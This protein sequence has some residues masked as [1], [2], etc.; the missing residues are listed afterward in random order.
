MLKPQNDK[1]EKI[2]TKNEVPYRDFAIR[3]RA[4][5]QARGISKDV[6]ITGGRWDSIGDDSGISYKLKKGR[7]IFSKMFGEVLATVDATVYGSPQDTRIGY[8]NKT[9]KEII[10]GQVPTFNS[11][12][13]NTFGKDFE[14][15][16][17]RI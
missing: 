7:G 16:I 5:I 3:L 2:I 10:E 17:R 1:M 9:I 15:Q 8:K 4:G 14:V 6:E 13:N 11:N 12:L